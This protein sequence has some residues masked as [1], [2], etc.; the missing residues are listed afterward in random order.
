MSFRTVEQLEVQGR[1][2]LVRL[3]LNVPLDG[4][5]ITDDLRIRA[6]LPTVRSIIERG[7][8]ALCMSHLGRPE[9]P[10]PSLSLA[11]VAERMGGLL[12]RRVELLPG[13][14]GEAVAARAAALPAGSVGLLENLRFEGGEKK[15]ESGFAAQLAALGELY[16]N[17]AFGTSH[18]AHA[19]V[20]GVPAVL[21]RERCAAGFLL[22]REL[23]AFARVLE[24]PPRPLVAI[25]G[26]AKVS[27]KLAVVRNLLP[28][29]DQVL[30]GGAMAYSFLAAR[31]VPVGASR[32]ETEQLDECRSVVESAGEKLLLPVDHLCAQAFESD[33][34]RLC[35]ASI[36]DGWMGLDIGFATAA[37]Y[38]E[39][40]AEA[41]SVVWN[42]PM[43]VFERKA[44]EGGTRAV[45]AA[46]AGCAGYTVVGGAGLR[47]GGSRRSP[48]HGW[49]RLAR[50]ARGSRPARH[51][52][53]HAL[54]PP[55]CRWRSYGGV[56]RMRA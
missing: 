24:D 30:V 9:G 35:E 41:G 29:V 43:G 8:T 19:S 38:T 45:A 36:P 25:L 31:G 11:P 5:R 21:G 32:V 39:R 28:R 1:R 49:R 48:L 23:T 54:K 13:V 33:E 46:V 27:D 51:R 14:V 26:G 4:G 37:R 12:E 50:T 20:V 6:A 52:G 16:V 22:G 47:A 44:Y 18:R 56:G 15:N 10:D 7:G 2:V 40:I 17:D 53:A 34:A 42:G 55:P 3:D